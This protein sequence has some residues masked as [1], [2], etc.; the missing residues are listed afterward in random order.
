MIINFELEND[1]LIRRNNYLIGCLQRAY[2]ENERL[3][4]S[5]IKSEITSFNTANWKQEHLKEQQRLRKRVA[6]LEAEVVAL[7]QDK[8]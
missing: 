2:K 6:E 3:R 5:L 1:R 7:K 4:E 8:R